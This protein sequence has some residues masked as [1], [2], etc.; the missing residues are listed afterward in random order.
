MKNQKGF[1]FVGLLTIVVIVGLLG[2]VGWLVYDRQK[3]KTFNL[4][5]S[6]KQ[7]AEAPTQETTK[8]PDPY[9]GWKTYTNSKL[10]YSFKYP[11]NW[12]VTLINDGDKLGAIQL[13][14][15]DAKT[16]ELPIGAVDIIKG[17]RVTLYTETSGDHTAFSGLQKQLKDE[18]I[19][20]P[21]KLTLGN[22]KAIEYAFAYEG[23]ETT[24]IRVATSDSRYI[25]TSFMSEGKESTHSN[26]DLYKKLLASI[27]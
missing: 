14:S 16:E 26:Y 10:S 11:R 20:K 8:A 22:H 27:K 13:D 3:N 5:D 15:P 2:A 24:Y 6:T 9:E 12:S 18:G 17:S 1:S 19:I 23:P 25:Q 21:V 7:T 4:Q